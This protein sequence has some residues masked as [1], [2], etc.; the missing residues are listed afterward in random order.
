MNSLDFLPAFPFHFSGIVLF[1]ALLLAGFCAGEGL[2][3]LLRLP[4]VTGYVLLGV[5]VGPGVLNWFDQYF[6]TQSRVFV[7]IALGMLLFE[8]GR[9]LDLT[10]YRRNPWVVTAG[11]AAG[12]LAFVF[13]LGM[14]V[15]LGIEPLVAALVAGIAM[16]TSPAVVLM[17]VRDLRAEGQVVERAM[18]V[19][20]LNS[21]MAFL[22][23]TVLW[24]GLHIS[25]RV[26]LATAFAHPLYLLAGSLL[27]GLAGG[28]LLLGLIRLVGPRQGRQFVVIVA[29]ILLAVG[30]AQVLKLS[31]LISLLTLGAVT[32][33]LDQLNLREVDLLGTGRLF[34]IVLFV[35][36]GASLK[37]DA[38]VAG[39][40][41]A[42]ALILARFCGKAIALTA[43]ASTSGISWRKALWLSVALLPMSGSAIVLAHEVAAMYPELG[44]KLTQIVYA[45]VAILEIVGPIA[46]QLALRMSNEAMPAESGSGGAHGKGAA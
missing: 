36:V 15:L 12:V 46:V 35:V 30:I 7:D 16:S 39:G 6:I 31:V 11:V 43:L 37:L 2:Y 20:A 34:I 44:A 40:W 10:W 23:V 18:T 4:K 45:T 42:L 13:V 21:I 1:G 26:G 17:V 27:I 41:V 22:A 8:A 19:V 38:M 14:L 29:V 9:Y 33:N 32:R 28:Y 5:L 3:R 25:H 24:S